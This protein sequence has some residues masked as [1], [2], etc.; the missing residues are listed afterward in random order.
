MAEMMLKY[1]LF[2]THVYC[3]STN[4]Y[5]NFK[6]NTWHE[7]MKGSYLSSS[8]NPYKYWNNVSR[9]NK[10]GMTDSSSNNE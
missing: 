8:E 9:D 3:K 1:D 7:G 5:C 2:R 4:T 6:L 10:Q